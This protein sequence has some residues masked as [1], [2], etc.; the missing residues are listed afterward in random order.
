MS[1][2]NLHCDTTELLEAFSSSNDHEEVAEEIQK[3]M[4]EYENTTLDIAITGESGA[5]KSTFI[6]ALL[7]VS[8]DDEDDAETG[9]TETTT[10]PK[11]YKHPQDQTVTYWDLPGLGTPSI[12][13]QQYYEKVHFE[14]YDFFIIIASERFKES[15]I[16]LAKRIQAMKK[17]FYFVWSKIDQDLS[18]AKRSKPSV[19]NEETILQTIRN[20]VVQKLKDGWAGNPLV[21]LISSFNL[22][23]Y[24]FNVMIETMKQEMPSHKRHKFILI[25]PNASL[26]IIQEKRDAL[27][28][29]IWKKALLS[30]IVSFVPIPGLS[31]ACDIPLMIN[32][33]KEYVKSL[34]LDKQTLTKLSDVWLKDIKS[35]IQSPVCKEEI[36]SSFALNILVS[37]ETTKEALINKGYFYA[38]PIFGSI[39]G[40]AVAFTTIRDILYKAL[41]EVV[42]DA[43]RVHEEIKKAIS[44]Q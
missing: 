28:G 36:N 3:E 22:N 11:A 38:I 33:L 34:C 13:S 42:D 23:L 18:N 5:G 41:D 2:D 25:L 20:D 6:N 21:F 35:V 10:E 16:D 43:K 27:R 44:E 29:Q 30:S 1:D 4:S 9:V 31:F 26:Q 19:Y 14:K 17:R 24:D 7:G 37:K 32:T 39:Y 12:K 8:Q 40:S 15:H